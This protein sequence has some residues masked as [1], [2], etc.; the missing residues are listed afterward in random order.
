[1]ELLRLALVVA[2]L[3]HISCDALVHRRLAPLHQ[4]L[5]LTA[6]RTFAS[7]TAP[8]GSKSTFWCRH[9]GTPQE[10]LIHYTRADPTGSR[11]EGGDPVLLLNGFGV[12]FFHWDR[13]IEPLAQLSGRPIY[14]MD[15]LGQGKSWPVGCEDG[16]SASESG[17]RYS[18]DDWVDQTIEFIEAIALGGNSCIHLVGNSLG[19]LMAA[20]VASQ[21]PDLV[22]SVVLVN[23]TPLWGGNLPG[24]D[25]RLPGPYLPRAV[26]RF[27][28]DAI[29]DLKNIRS[30]LKRTYANS[31]QLGDLPGRIRA[32]TE[33]SAG[34]HAAFASI[35][36]ARPP[37]ILKLAD[38]NSGES[39][40]TLAAVRGDFYDALKALRCPVL[41]LYGKEDPWCSPEFGRAANR[42]LLD[43]NHCGPPAATVYVE[44]SPC[45]HCPH[46]E[47]PEATNTIL[48][49]WL[50]PSSESESGSGPA[51]HL[52]PPSGTEM[53]GSITAKMVNASSPVSAWELILTALIR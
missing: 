8:P 26:G 30:L 45:G 13:N 16:N 10:Q 23:A 27:M 36:W 1:M 20:V 25:A 32:V 40:S 14:A 4:V 17:L 51:Q 12:G 49:R 50:A 29:R 21:R 7:K 39:A 9:H 2:L 24:W 47:T 31:S 41:L 22:R 33:E 35:M 3:E 6:T 52:L 15:Y 19:G 18:F 37:T 38:V 34:G 28:Y 46:H 42:A 43:R 11:V 48:G 53:F 5:R 44:L